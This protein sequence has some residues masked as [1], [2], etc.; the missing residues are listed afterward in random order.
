MNIA[1]A[2]GAT[3]LPA[4]DP[5]EV[6]IK[7]ARQ[8]G[9]RHLAIGLLGC[10]LVVAVIA[11][12]VLLR[13]IGGGREYGR[14]SGA[15]A[16]TAVAL[17]RIDPSCNGGKGFYEPVTGGLGNLVYTETTNNV[18]LVAFDTVTSS[19]FAPLAP[20]VIYAIS[21]NCGLDRSFGSNGFLTPGIPARGL[22]ALAPGLDGKFFMLATDKSGFWIS[23]RNADGT[24]DNRF[25]R[26]G[27][28]SIVSPVLKLAGWSQFSDTL[29]QKQNGTIVVT[30]EVINNQYEYGPIQSYIYALHANGEP[31]HHFGHDGKVSF[32]PPGAGALSNDSG[33]AT[34]IQPNGTIAVIGWFG[35]FNQLGG[36]GFGGPGCSH[37]SIE[38]LNS[39]GVPEHSVDANFVEQNS[40]VRTAGFVGSEFIDASG[41]VGLVGEARPCRGDA[42]YGKPFSVVEALTPNGRLEPRFGNRGELRFSIPDETNSNGFATAPL[43]NG[44]FVQESDTSQYFFQDFTANGQ[45]NKGFGKRGLVE[46][47]S[48]GDQAV[49]PVNLTAG[50]RGDFVVVLPTS[51][52][53]IM[54][55][56]RG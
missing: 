48:P 17:G 51:R 29:I 45:M 36:E 33:A 40:I 55:E 52:G 6:L 8:R 7:E 10:L 21:P 54:S 37:A 32:K 18:T 30:G 38:W 49:Q 50:A 34:L 25:G 3:V 13:V 9:R 22:S 35:G 31:V 27:W 26:H 5:A 42:Q 53:I 47:N 20:Y 11:T 16:D 43:P 14:N 4:L 56:R 1:P 39:N 23:E 24:I 15:I 28:I 46:L 12:L 2:R 41:G 44:H 19:N